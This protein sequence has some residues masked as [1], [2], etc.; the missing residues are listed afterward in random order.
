MI[1]DQ[2]TRILIL[3][4]GFAGLEAARVLERLIPDDAPVEITLLN[5]DNFFL[6]S[7]MLPEVAGSSIDA[8]HIVSP[9][10][11][12]VGRT[13]FREC[14]VVSIDLERRA[15]ATVHSI[16]K[17]RH[18]LQYDHLALTL[19][20]VTNFRDTPGV[21]DHALTLKSLA[22]AVLVRDHIL[23]CLEQAEMETDPELRKALLTFVVAGGGFSGAELIAE[24]L[25]FAYE[26]CRFYPT[27]NREDVRVILIHHGERLLPEIGPELADYALRAL[28]R[29]GV[30]IRLNTGVSSAD[31]SSVTTDGGE[32]IKTHNLVW[33]AGVAP[34]PVVA[35]LQVEKDRRGAILVDPY[36]RARGRSNVWAAGDCANVTDPATGQP[37]PPTAQHALRQARTLAYNLAATIRGG[38]LK[39]FAFKSP[40]VLVALG[41]HSAAAEIWGRRFRGFP[42]WFL[43]R[44]IY[45]SKLPSVERKVRVA[46]DWTLDLFFPRN[47][48]QLTHLG[49]RPALRRLAQHHHR[50]VGVE[51]PAPSDGAL[52]VVPSAPDEKRHGPS[53]GE[54]G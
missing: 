38:E 10:R 24:V 13:K 15:V 12:F 50:Q 49:I 7:P 37:Y 16:T 30:E 22:D 48:C 28:Q 23:A 31:R 39:P 18:T 41:H 3:G 54:S 1:T 47:M 33:T 32:R 36:L 14:E 27:I 25:D 5:R 43:W 21:E 26:A 4:G 45:L 6:F 52:V 29:R 34:S 19:G 17:H 11:A 44:S 42:A 9:Q 35:Q 40:G 51:T 46:L 8:E 20:S 2:P 53:P